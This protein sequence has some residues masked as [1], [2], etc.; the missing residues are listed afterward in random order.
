MIKKNPSLSS[1][2]V[3]KFWIHFSESWYIKR[4]TKTSS[5]QCFLHTLYTRDVNCWWAK[6]LFVEASPL[7]KAEEIR[8]LEYDPWATA[9]EL[10]QGGSV[11]G[12]CWS[13]WGKGGQV[14]D[15][16]EAGSG[17]QQSNPLV[18]RKVTTRGNQVLRLPWLMPQL[19]S[20][21]YSEPGSDQAS[22]SIIILQEM[23]ETA[24]H[25]RPHHEDAVD[26]IQGVADIQRDPVSSA[27]SWH[28]G[29][30]GERKRQAG[31]AVMRCIIQIQCM[32]LVWIGK[33]WWS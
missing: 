1:L 3:P 5:S 14:L 13:S 24:E 17:W 12:S 21:L 11:P 16:T 20:G 23:L 25:V 22:G 2:E 10:T 6:V 7:R 28:G 26:W 32:G 4:K 27:D 31:R 9:N 33:I 15:Q 29:G 18:T 30:S 19:T 8:E